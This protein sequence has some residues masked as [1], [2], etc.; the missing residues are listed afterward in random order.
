VTTSYISI[1]VVSDYGS[2]GLEPFE[3]ESMGVGDAESSVIVDVMLVASIEYGPGE[4]CS[5]SDQ[6][7]E[8]AWVAWR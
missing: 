6:T 2:I 1:S 5:V 3:K 8:L 7:D 4:Q